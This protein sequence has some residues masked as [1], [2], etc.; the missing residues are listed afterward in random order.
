[1]NEEIIINMVKPY[2]KN[3]SITYNEFDSIYNFLSKKEQYLVVEILFK[4][5]IC[6]VDEE[7]KEESYKTNLHNIDKNKLNNDN[8]F[9]DNGKIKD[10]LD[11]VNYT[12]IKQSNEIL[13]SLIKQ[14]NRQSKQDLC[15]KNKQLIDK[16]VCEYQKYYSNR[17]DFEDLEQ[18]GYIGLIKAA[19][20]YN[21]NMGTM[22]STYAVFWIKQS[23][24]R[25]IMN[26]GFAIRIPV[27]MMEKIN[28]VT[29][30][31]HKLI[32]QG[33]EYEER[34]QIVC[35]E[36]GE[37]QNVVKKCLFF[38]DS[39]LSY[40]SLN[41]LIGEEENTEILEIIKD[42][43][44]PSIE[45]IVMFKSLQETLRQVLNT[46]KPRERDILKLRFGIDDGRTRTLEEVGEVYGLTRERIRQIEKKAIKKMRHP[47]RSKKLRE[48]IKK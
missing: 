24:F 36:I 45:D 3:N 26:N 28:K 30:L 27:Y 8:L 17:L 46:L 34:L 29:R 2:I 40:T 38:R 7:V 33:I 11:L 16:Y 13:C 21:S 25:E 19:E 42:D 12:N 15:I 18:V 44:Q 47:S 6:L 22:F 32:A 41:S 20:R 9:K 10:D 31:N 48:Y 43:M 37:T 4:N 39:V 35:D 14:N 5:N 1:M 23:I